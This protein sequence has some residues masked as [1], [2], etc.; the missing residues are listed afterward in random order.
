MRG[1]G[2]RAFFLDRD[3]VINKSPGEG[4]VTCWEQFRFLPGVLDALRLLK[5]QKELVIIVSNQSVV[6]RGIIS[7]GQLRRI[8]QR[9]LRGI[10]SAGGAVEEV[11]Y[12]MHHPKKKCSCRKPLIRMLVK[13]QKKFSIDLKKSFMIGDEDKDIQMG[14]RAGCR[15]IL[16]LSGKSRRIETKRWVVQPD[17]IE[18]DLLRAVQR[19]ILLERNKK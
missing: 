10:T 8:T 6:G 11:Y 17:R 3:G 9:M 14:H 12:C 13:A 19:V 1:K 2:K 4:F 15:T 16:V 7:A 18:K 5:K